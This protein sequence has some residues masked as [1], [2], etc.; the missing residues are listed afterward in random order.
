MRRS[1]SLAARGSVIAILISHRTPLEDRPKE[2][3]P[4]GS[5][6]AERARER[7]RAGRIR[8][9]S[10][11]DADPK[12]GLAELRQLEQQVP[13]RFSL[14]RGPGQ[15]PRARGAGDLDLVEEALG[16]ANREGARQ[17]AEGR[18]GA[19]EGLRVPPLD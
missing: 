18:A 19:D 6:A 7:H 13:G 5:A 9:R 15:L 14:A 16:G 12:R 8:L 1:A 4:G 17:V 3:G 2:T 11:R 10:K